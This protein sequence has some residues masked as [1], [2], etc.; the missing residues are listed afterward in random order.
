MGAVLGSRVNDTL[1]KVDESGNIQETLTRDHCWRAFTPQIFRISALREALLDAKKD[2]VSVS[3]EAMAM[4]RMGISGS[5]V[6]GLE[7][8]IKITRPQDLKLAKLFIREFR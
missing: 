7:S 5:M 8:N 3:D 1:K 6:Q 4:E 2:C